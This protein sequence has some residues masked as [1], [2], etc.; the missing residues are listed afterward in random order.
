MRSVYVI[1]PM[2]IIVDVK[3]CHCE[4]V[5]PKSVNNFVLSGM[6]IIGRALL[7]LKVF[8]VVTNISVRTV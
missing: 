7:P 2:V 1:Y 6:H 8:A 5:S 3:R 4:T